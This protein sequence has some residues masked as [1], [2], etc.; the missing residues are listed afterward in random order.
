MN[1]EWFDMKEEYLDG[2]EDY[3]TYIIDSLFEDGFD[4]HDELD[5]N[6][7]LLQA[8]SINYEFDEMEVYRNRVNFIK[9]QILYSSIIY[10]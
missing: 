1:E 2:D 6:L 4:L 5:K 8:A 7:I 3:R 9:W 10:N